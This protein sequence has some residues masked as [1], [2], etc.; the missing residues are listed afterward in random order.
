MTQLTK[1]IL[2]Y[3][4]KEENYPDSLF[5]FWPKR[6]PPSTWPAPVVK[7]PPRSRTWSHMA[8]YYG[9][10]NW[11]PDV[12]CGP[13]CGRPSQPSSA[14]PS[15]CPMSR[16][17]GMHKYWVLTAEQTPHLSGDGTKLSLT[18]FPTL[19]QPLHP[20]PR[21]G[22]G[23]DHDVFPLWYLLHN[24]YNEKFGH[25]LRNFGNL[26]HLNFFLIIWKNPSYQCGKATFLALKSAPL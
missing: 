2:I 14:P 18:P 10:R 24:K 1:L 12:T 25:F 8:T 9:I 6:V 15:S 11:P 5:L 13:S 3:S 19:C 21:P 22:H 23:V 20:Q 26:Q 7:N 17:A 16:R 4:I